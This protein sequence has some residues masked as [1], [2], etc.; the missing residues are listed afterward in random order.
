MDEFRKV[1]F[2]YPP[3]VLAGAIALA[4]YFDPYESI[5][6]R[7]FSSP[8]RDPT[9]VWTILIGGGTG[10][11]AAGYVLGTASVV[12]LRL[13]PKGYYDA[14]VLPQDR[15]TLWTRVGRH[16]SPES[17]QDLSAVAA[18]DHGVLP[19]GLREWINRRWQA[20]N[21]SVHTTLALLLA[22]WIVQAAKLNPTSTWYWINSTLVLIFACH[23]YSAWMDT[24]RM[25]SFLV[26][27]SNLPCVFRCAKCVSEEE[28]Q[29]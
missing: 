24:A 22:F 15:P 3:L 5:Q 27:V 4:F 11:L 26:N 29:G 10:I 1:R 28:R 6:G 13:W 7:Y 20:F 18:F 17:A 19:A 12:L 14:A 25:N 21:L 8:G 23:S 2:L 16:G 9:F